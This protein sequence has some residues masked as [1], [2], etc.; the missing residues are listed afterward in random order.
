MHLNSTY[1]NNMKHVHGSLLATQGS[2]QKSLKRQYPNQIGKQQSS[3]YGPIQLEPN[4]VFSIIDE[5]MEKMSLVTTSIEM[6]DDT[7]LSPSECASSDKLA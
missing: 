6:K 3:G 7:A 2:V 1:A 5:H 4:P